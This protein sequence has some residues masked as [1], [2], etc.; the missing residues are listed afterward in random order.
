MHT[1]GKGCLLTK[2]N[3]M[4]KPEGAYLFYCS[5]FLFVYMYEFLCATMCEEMSEETNHVGPSRQTQYTK[6]SSKH[7]YWLILL[8]ALFLKRCFCIRSI[9]PSVQAGFL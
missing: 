5:Y 6:L 4:L 7:L 9:Y 8:P 3:S 2:E 1:K